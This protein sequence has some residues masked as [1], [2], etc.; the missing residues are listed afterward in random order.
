MA[1]S[2]ADSDDL[3][4]RI[5]EQDRFDAEETMVDAIAATMTSTGSVGSRSIGSN[6]S[7]QRRSTRA[8]S[9]LASISISN[10]RRNRAPAIPPPPNNMKELPTNRKQWNI[11][12]VFVVAVATVAASGAI[13]VGV[14]HAT[15]RSSPG[16]YKTTAAAVILVDKPVRLREMPPSQHHR[17]QHTKYSGGLMPDFF[18]LNSKDFADVSHYA[19]VPVLW[20]IPFSGDEAWT[21]IMGVCMQLTQASDQQELL[22]AH[23]SDHELKYVMTNRGAFFN[24]DLSSWEG[25]EQAKAVNLAALDRVDIITSP[26]LSVLS[27]FDDLSLQGRS[28]CTLR[29][30]AARLA[31]FFYASKDASSRYYDPAMM[32]VTIDQYAAWP[33]DRNEFNFMV[34]SLVSSGNE[35]ISSGEITNEDMDLA[36]SILQQKFMILL[37]EDT[38]GSWTKLQSWL[39]WTSTQ[40]Q[41]KCEDAAMDKDWLQTP[42]EYPV[43]GSDA[44]AYL[45]LSER[46]NWDLQLYEF[47]V[48]IFQQQTEVLVK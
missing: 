37:A 18:Q 36:K 39:G 42:L 23:L 12:K 15:H 14:L 11:H 32:D 25:I 31:S 35:L 8:P 5:D 38:F 26:L 9:T 34:K 19:E 46:N 20:R 27:L 41:R 17:I 21:E 28:F 43:L 16:G 45:H 29:H 6:Y 4:R 2:E 40:E 22:G 44:P 24:I 47:A 13:A 33:G 3:R 30:P 48:Q 7:G 1:I 10:K